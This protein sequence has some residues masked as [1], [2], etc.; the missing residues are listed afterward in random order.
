MIFIDEA[1]VN[2]AMTRLYARALRDY[3][4]TATQP[5]ARGKS[6]TMVGALGLKGVV[7]ALIYT[8]GT[9]GLT[10]KTFVEQALLP[11]LWPGVRA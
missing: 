11:Q 7:T 6:I 2:L 4:A 10:F 1:G 5:S 9:D 3:K 8:G